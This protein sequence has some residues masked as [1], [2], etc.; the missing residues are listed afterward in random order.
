MDE[1]GAELEVSARTGRFRDPELERGY[2]EHHVDTWVR[3]AYPRIMAIS[4]AI[5][6]AWGLL[7]KGFL[8]ADVQGLAFGVRFGLMV[9]LHVALWA[10]ARRPGVDR[11]WPAIPLTLAYACALHVFWVG[12]SL[13]SPLGPLGRF[14]PVVFIALTPLVGALRPAHALGLGLSTT[15]TLGAVEVVWGPD[16]PAVAGFIAAVYLLATLVA[17]I[18]ARSLHA[19]RRR[20][21]WQSLVIG[22]QMSELAKERHKSD[23]LLLN[24]LPAPI[25]QRLKDD[26]RDIADSFEDVTV[27]FADLVGFTKLASR[28]SAEQLVRHLDA[29]FTEFDHLAADLGLEKIKTIG[30]AYMV[31]GGLPAPLPD[32]AAAVVRMAQGMLW[33]VERYAAETGEALSVRVGVHSGPVVAGVIGRHKFI[34]DLWGDTVNVASRM[35]SH[36]APGRIQI[37]EA[38]RQRLGST[39]DLE[40]RGA[41]EVKGKGPMRTWFVAPQRRSVQASLPDHRTRSQAA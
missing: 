14:F 27:L 22:W 9:P 21:F 23:G 20:A 15:A 39:F 35:E 8:P 17:W 34:Y 41:I 33:V 38:T 30:D 7:D 32:H 16:P 40:P 5:Y 12:L 29:L 25:A 4:L 1:A 36:G 11:L 31:A 13:P 37:S 6:V 3:P 2:W 24:V 19:I 18:G 26:E 10:L 28:L